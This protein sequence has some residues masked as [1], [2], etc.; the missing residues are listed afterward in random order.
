MACI[1]PDALRRHN[2]CLMVFSAWCV[3]RHPTYASGGNIFTALMRL[4]IASFGR[5]PGHFAGH[6]P[7]SVHCCVVCA[8]P[9]YSLA[10][11]SQTDVYGLQ[12]NCRGTET[13]KTQIGGK[14]TT[15]LVGF[16][17]WLP[18]QA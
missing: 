18:N 8:V 16:T 14:S 4:G 11:I 12:L 13:R 5:A 10:V 3:R 7:A 1:A 17:R 6:L 9:A 2:D 15:W